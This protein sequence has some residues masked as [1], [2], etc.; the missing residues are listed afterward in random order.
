MTEKTY[1]RFEA[2]QED[3][4]LVSYEIAASST[5][6]DTLEAFLCF[7]MACG[8]AVPWNATIEIVNP[9]EREEDRGHEL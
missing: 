4:Q 7:L 6:D 3:G 8:Y 5:L 2:R 1:I 9:P